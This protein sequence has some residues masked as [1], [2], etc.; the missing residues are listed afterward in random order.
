M[1]TKR[2]RTRKRTA[3]TNRRS[4]ASRTKTRALKNHGEKF[5][6]WVPSERVSGLP[7]AS[8]LCEY[9]RC[10]GRLLEDGHLRRPAARRSPGNHFSIE[11]SR[12]EF[13]AQ[14]TGDGAGPAAGAGHVAAEPAEHAIS[15]RASAHPCC[16][17]THEHSGAAVLPVRGQLRRLGGNAL[18]THRA[19]RTIQQSPSVLMPYHLFAV[20]QSSPRAQGVD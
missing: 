3:P 9:F 13:P 19:A 16:A 14:P 8:F 17:V 15:S 11:K 1:K 12:L 5:G 2:K 7:D 6:L 10:V 18:R 20:A 4:C